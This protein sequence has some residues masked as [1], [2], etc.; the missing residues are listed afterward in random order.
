MVRRLLD[1]L[2]GLTTE[3][4]AAAQDL[5]RRWEALDDCGLPDTLVHGDFHPGNWRCDG[6]RT[7]VLDFA[8]AHFGN[9][10]LDGL[11]VCEFLPEAMRP[12]AVRAWVDAWRTRR[13]GADPARAMAVAAPLGRLVYAVRYQEFLDGIEPS[14]RVYHLDDPIDSV[15]AALALSH[16]P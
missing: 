10:V 8:D 4:R 3:E 12:I 6:G 11:R 2:P 14:E 9:P 1:D 7:A 15:R 16:R 5:L 13:P